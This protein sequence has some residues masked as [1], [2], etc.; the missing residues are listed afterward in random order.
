M[1][2]A[3]K[4]LRAPAPALVDYP[5]QKH[6]RERSALRHDPFWDALCDSARKPFAVELDPP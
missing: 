6:E 1:A 3:A 4:A 5:A 2:A